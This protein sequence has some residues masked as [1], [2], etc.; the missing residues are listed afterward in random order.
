MKKSNTICFILLVLA[1]V[2]CYLSNNDIEK[3]SLEK[4]NIQYYS[5]NTITGEEYNFSKEY[6]IY[7]SFLNDNEK[8]LYKQIYANAINYKKI[9]KPITSVKVERLKLIIE[10]VYNDHPELFYL[11]TN[12]FYKYDENNNCIEITLNYNETINNIDKNKKL[13][14]EKLNIIINNAKRYKT[15]YE[16]EKYVYNYLINNITYDKE[17]KLNQSIYSALIYGKTVCAGYAR[18]FQLIMQMLDIPTYYVLGY[19]KEDHAWNIIKLDGGYYNVDLT[20]DDTGIRNSH[21]N[22]PDLYIEKTHSR[23][24]ISKYL[25]YCY[26]YKYYKY[27]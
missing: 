22:L 10:S 17:S 3:I 8:E 11:D 12:Y 13:I 6:Y 19:A 16:K 26:D 15:D 1:L 18:T 25:P 9:I 24:G 20:W 21:F 4:E 7:Y 2:L 27:E 23:V 14:N 5:E